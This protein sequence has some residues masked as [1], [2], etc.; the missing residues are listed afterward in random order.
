MKI[1]DWYIF[2]KFMVTFLFAILTI[3]VIAVVIDTSEKTDDFV[4]SGLP[5][6]GIVT[7]YYFGFVPFIISMIFPL[8][9]FIAVIFFTS[10]MA[11][12]SETVAILA[13]GIPYSRFLRPYLMGAFLLA[14]IMLWANAMVIPR[15][16]EIYSRFKLTYIDKNSTYS[17]GIGGSRDFYFRSDSVTFVGMK[18][19]DTLNKSASNFFLERIKGNEVI[20]NIRSDYVRW[21]TATKKWR[22]ENVFERKI[23]GLKE[24]VQKHPYMEVDLNM[25]PDELRRDEYLKDKLNSFELYEFIRREQ[26]RG[27]EGLNT[28]RVEFWRRLATPVSV[29]ILTLMG[30]FV[31]ARKTRGGSGLQLAF[32]IVSAATFVIMDKFSTVFSTKGN[33]HP[34]LAAWLPNLI[35]MLVAF[36]LYKKAPK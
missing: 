17:A 23:D 18:Y 33:F 30:V 27:T 7:Q 14:G 1:L 36:Y 12:R 11:A 15:A 31:A 10:K 2:K 34:I 9:V 24:T 25:R 32:G 26:I 22:A 35:F 8:I 21:D 29:I 28:Y 16:N 6:M 19:Y 13:T 5:F 3:T 4:K 20:Y